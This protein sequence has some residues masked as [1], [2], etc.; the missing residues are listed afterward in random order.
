MF[1]LEEVSE[2]A[3][4]LEDGPIAGVGT[5]NIKLVSNPNFENSITM[6]IE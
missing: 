2:F 5:P 6:L 1:R 3:F 4:F